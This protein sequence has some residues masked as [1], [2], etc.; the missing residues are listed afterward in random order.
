MSAPATIA[1]EPHAS[2]VFAPSTTAA[3][4][5]G[6]SWEGWAR[7]VIT[8]TPLVPV[9]LAATAGVVLER[10]TNLPVEREFLGVDKTLLVLIALGLTLG[11]CWLLA[12]LRGRLLLGLVCLWLVCGLLG[13]SWHR[14][15]RMPASDD[16]GLQATAEGRLARVRG[17]VQEVEHTTPIPS[18][19]RSRLDPPQTELV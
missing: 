17:T 9:A 16:I 13:A 2:R 5:A 8:R 3:G 12:W 11:I 10:V 6:V 14:L 18:P 19:L 1:G 4:Q 15:W 7:E